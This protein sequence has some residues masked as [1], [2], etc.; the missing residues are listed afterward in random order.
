VAITKIE[1]SDMILAG[2]LFNESGYDLEKSAENLA[3][4]K[5]NII[6]E[7]LE[8]LFPGVEICA[9]IAIQM[10][11]G[12]PWRLEVMVYN[13]KNEKNQEEANAILSQLTQKIAEGTADRSW[14]VKV[15]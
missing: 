6:I 7:H 5:G 12:K 4:L 10:E 15:A 3:E 11:D 8:G 13:E 14:A 9:D 2:T 1:I